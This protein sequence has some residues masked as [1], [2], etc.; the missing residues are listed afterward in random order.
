MITPAIS[1][2]SAVEGLRIATPRFHPRTTGR[3]DEHKHSRRARNA[4]RALAQRVGHER[5]QRDDNAFAAVIGLRQHADVLDRDDEDQRP[6]NQ[7]DAAEHVGCNGG[8]DA[9]W[10][11]EALL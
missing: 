3:A 11:G 4:G 8:G 1:V 10:T 5:E 2:L 9:M 7:R 6:D